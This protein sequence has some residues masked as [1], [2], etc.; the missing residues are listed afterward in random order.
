MAYLGTLIPVASVGGI[1]VLPFWFFE[2]LVAFLQ[3]F[4]FMT[5]SGVYLK[6]SLTVAEHH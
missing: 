6:E 4:I 5:L 3:A 1:L 2:L